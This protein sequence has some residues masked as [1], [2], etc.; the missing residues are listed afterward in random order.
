MVSN[1]NVLH[2][3]AVQGRAE[4]RRETYRWYVEQ[5]AQA[6]TQQC[7]KNPAAA[8]AAS[9]MGRLGGAGDSQ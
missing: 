3:D 1:V 8:P 6:L 7:T 4:Q 9:P 5:A 2:L